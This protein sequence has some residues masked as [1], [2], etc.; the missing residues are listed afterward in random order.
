[1]KATLLIFFL[2]V[3]E[4]GVFVFNHK[5][6]KRKLFLADLN[7]PTHDAEIEY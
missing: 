7:L 3:A 4:W 6:K 1:M 5:R 2:P